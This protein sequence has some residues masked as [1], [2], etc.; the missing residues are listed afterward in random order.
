[1]GGDIRPPLSTRCSSRS[2]STERVNICHRF[3]IGFNFDKMTTSHQTQPVCQTHT[4]CQTQTDNDAH[5]ARDSLVHTEPQALCG[6]VYP[7]GSRVTADPAVWWG[8]IINTATVIC[9]ARAYGDRW[10]VI[11]NTNSP[12]ISDTLQDCI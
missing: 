2:P 5:S 6:S 3:G 4:V 12:Y 7:L 10:A 9:K 11:R 8:R 1:M